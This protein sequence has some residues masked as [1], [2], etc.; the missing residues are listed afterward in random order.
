MNLT[1]LLK[2]PCHLVVRISLIMFLTGVIGV[3]AQSNI[4]TNVY[5]STGK[6]TELVRCPVGEYELCLQKMSDLC[7]QA[8]YDILEKIRQVKTGVWSDTSEFLIIAQCK[9]V[10]YK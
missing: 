5:G 7:Q 2:N 4:T 8:G 10:E 9:S 6:P 3:R 1:R